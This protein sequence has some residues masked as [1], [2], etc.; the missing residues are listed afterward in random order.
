M[1]SIFGILSMAGAAAVLFLA[2]RNKKEIAI[3]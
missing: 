1:Y 3:R 2:G